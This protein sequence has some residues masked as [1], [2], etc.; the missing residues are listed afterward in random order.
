MV[1]TNVIYIYLCVNWHN[2]IGMSDYERSR[3]A[4]IHKKYTPSAS[5]PISTYG[6]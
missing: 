1:E 4:H 5:Q 2:G 6:F 3:E